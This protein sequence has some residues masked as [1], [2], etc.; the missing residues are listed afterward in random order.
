MKQSEM[1]GPDQLEETISLS[2]ILTDLLKPFHNYFV[3]VGGEFLRVRRRW[4]TL[5]YLKNLFHCLVVIFVEFCFEF[6][7]DCI[8]SIVT[9]QFP[10][11]QSIPLLCCCSAKRSSSAANDISVQQ[12]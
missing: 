9:S 4:T 11:L 7:D 6:A 1:I 8:A 5:D 10:T 3:A 2:V 12:T